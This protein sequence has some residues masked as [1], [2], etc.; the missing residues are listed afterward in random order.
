MTAPVL[1]LG[2]KV[3]DIGER[4]SNLDESVTDETRGTQRK[5]IFAADVLF[6]FDKATLTGKARSRLE[7]AAE[8][9]KAEAAGKPVAIDGYTDAKGSGSY[10][11][12]LSR[13]RAQAVRAALAE[14]VPGAR[15]TVAGHGEADPVAPN[16]LPDGGDNPEGRAKNR[17]V[18][19]S[20][21]R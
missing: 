4:I 13:R 12:E 20:F 15:F 16:A 1:D 21:T 18:E 19:I 7:L 10:N 6:A 3:L 14:L 9:L 11:L 2:G 5:I 8:S 17:R